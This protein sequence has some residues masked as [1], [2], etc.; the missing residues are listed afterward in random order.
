M[1]ITLRNVK[2]S[3]LTFTELDTNFSDL[4][5]LKAPKA[6]PTFTGTVTADVLTATGNVSLGN[7]STDTVTL[8]GATAVI[9]AGAPASLYGGSFQV[10]ATDAYIEITNG[11]KALLFGA[12]S[13]TPFMGTYSDHDLV[14]RTNNTARFTLDSSG[15]WLN[16]GNTQPFVLATRSTTLQS[17]A[18][19]I[20]NNE[21]TDQGNVYDSSTGV[22]TAPVAGIY[23]FVV[24]ARFSNNSGSNGIG[25][26]NAVFSTAGTINI[27]RSIVPTAQDW[28]VTG[29]IQIR[30][31]ASETAT[32]LTTTS[33]SAGSWEMIGG[34]L[35]ARLIG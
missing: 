28:N 3:P 11:T 26:I 17:G 13:G 16:P 8:T 7:A 12:D 21:I 1:A 14:F 29:T 22:F 20:Y 30:L 10:R 31:A 32:F 5:T 27:V 6:S 9:G 23:E 4:D 33:F 18:T 25:S 19:L 35:N 24:A 15:R 34:H 2:G